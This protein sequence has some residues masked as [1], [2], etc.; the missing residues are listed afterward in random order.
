ME[1]I[2][3]ETNNIEI[4][5]NSVIDSEKIN[6]GLSFLS[7]TI[8]LEKFSVENCEEILGISTAQK[9]AIMSQITRNLRGNWYYNSYKETLGVSKTVAQDLAKQE[10]YNQT[11]KNL[12]SK[13]ISKM[14]KSIPGLSSQIN[15]ILKN[16]SQN[17]VGNDVI[18]LIK[19][20]SSQQNFNV[21]EE[22]GKLHR[23]KNFINNLS[24]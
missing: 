3:I 5:N 9:S 19:T 23:N 7:E 10:I 17:T 20:N 8:D 11:I 18:N 21:K 6:L 16:N 2:S 14:Y 15:Y 24:Q 1:T 4:E 12:A 22:I 13:K